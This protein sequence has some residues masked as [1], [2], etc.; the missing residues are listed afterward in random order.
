MRQPQAVTASYLRVGFDAEGA[1]RVFGLRE[2]FHPAAK[3]QMEDDITASVVVPA[4]AFVSAG[5]GWARR[6]SS[7]QNCER[8]SLPAARTTPST[9]A[10]TG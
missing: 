1:W 5:P 4:G 7:S 8:L 2:D 9:G 3:V 6:S 10:T